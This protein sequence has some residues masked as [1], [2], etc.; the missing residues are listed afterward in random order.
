MSTYKIANKVKGIIRAQ[1]S[2]PIGNQIATYVNEPFMRLDNIEAVLTFTSFDATPKVHDKNLLN[3]NHDTLTQVQLSGIPISDKILSL[4]Y[5][6]NTEA[7]LFHKQKYYES[8]VEGKIY[9]SISGSDTHIYQ[10]FIYDE[11]G[12]LEAS[13]GEFDTSEPL[14]VA[15]ADQTYSIYYSVL[16]SKSY[17]LDKP[18]NLYITLDLELTGNTDDDTRDMCVHIEKASIKTDRNMYLN[19]NTSNTINITA[20]VIYTGLDYITVE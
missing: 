13:Y 15:K 17:Y 4:L 1:H 18:D 11:E 14:V 5:I 10:V 8:D 19:R 7:P 9:L 16:G 12:N 2:G 20:S 3:F 6:P